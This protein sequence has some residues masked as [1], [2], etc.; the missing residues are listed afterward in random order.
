M[1]G[2]LLNIEK[3]LESNLDT[4]SLTLNFKINSDNWE[5]VSNETE[6]KLFRNGTQVN[7][8]NKITLA[9]C[10]HKGFSSDHLTTTKSIFRYLGSCEFINDKAKKL[11]LISQVK[12]CLDHFSETLMLLQDRIITNMDIPT[13]KSN[14]LQF[15]CVLLNTKTETT[16]SGT[17]IINKFLALHRISIIISE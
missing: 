12:H 10:Y 5:I 14:L 15:Q 1:N 6:L 17:H 3:W 16:D 7:I 13:L 8:E 11:E 2:T 9:T 4:S